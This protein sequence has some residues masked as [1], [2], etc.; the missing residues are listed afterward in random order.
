M[1][2]NQGM[3]VPAF[4]DYLKK[5]ADLYPKNI[6]DIKLNRNEILFEVNKLSTKRIEKLNNKFL[7][8][9]KIKVQKV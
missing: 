8:G 4:L 3:K 7:G 1:G 9:K 5:H 6:G 2:T